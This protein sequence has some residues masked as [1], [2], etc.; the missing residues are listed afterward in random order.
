MTSYLVDNVFF[1]ALAA[2]PFFEDA[3]AIS[4]YFKPRE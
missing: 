3:L 4:A 2:E 1:E